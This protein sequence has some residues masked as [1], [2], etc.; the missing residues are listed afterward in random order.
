MYQY[1]AMAARGAR[2][3]GSIEAE[4]ETAAVRQLSEQGL[5]VVELRAID[6]SIWTRDINVHFGLFGGVKLEQFVPFCRQFAT[7]VRAGVPLVN[8]LEVLHEQT[9]KGML[10]SAI[11]AV[12]ASVRD[13]RPLWES[14]AEHP[15]AFPPLFVQMVRAGEASGTLDEVLENTAGYQERQRET[16]EKIRSAMIY[17]I[18]VAVMAVVVSIFLLLRVIPTFVSVFAAQHIQLPLPTRIVLGASSLITH[19]WYIGL[20]IVALILGAVLWVNRHGPSLYWRDRILLRIPVFGQLVEKRAMAQVSRTL[21]MLFHAALPALQAIALSA[22]A[23]GNRYVAGALREVRDAL[24]DGGSLSGALRETGAF[25]P[26]MVQ[27]VRVGEATGHLDEMLAKVA[28]FYESELEMMV[29]RL[30]QLMEPIL[31]ALLAGVVGIIVLAALLPM[32]ALYQGMG[33]ST[34]M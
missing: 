22:D 21:A 14:L 8:S 31:T 34:G 3:R 24:G 20:M 6:E 13:G 33:S 19:R 23:V 29:D 27:M 15:R 7:L 25:S 9:E 1:E 18:V 28:D 11:F 32:F 26:L 10:K 4:D 5:Y 16:I 17:P 12:A 30:R 2:S